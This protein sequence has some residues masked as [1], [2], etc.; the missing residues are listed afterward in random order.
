VR[1]VKDHSGKNLRHNPA[2]KNAKF[3]CVLSKIFYWVCAAGVTCWELGTLR[4]P[5]WTDWV[6]ALGDPKSSLRYLNL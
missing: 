2:R 3:F 4:H 1:E 6:A 5:A